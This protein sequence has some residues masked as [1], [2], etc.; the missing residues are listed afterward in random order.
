MTQYVRSEFRKFYDIEPNILKSIIATEAVLE[1]PWNEK[2]M[3]PLNPND[4]TKV[5]SGINV[6]LLKVKSVLDSV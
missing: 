1:G 2:I 3:V 6:L 5:N 4:N